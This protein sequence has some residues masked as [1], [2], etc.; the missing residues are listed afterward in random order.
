MRNGNFTRQGADHHPLFAQLRFGIGFIAGFD[1]SNA[2]IGF[3]SLFSLPFSFK[4]LWALPINYCTP[5]R[6]KGRER[7]CWLNV[8]LLGMSVALLAI[9]CLDPKE[10]PWFLATLLVIVSSFA[11]CLYIAGIAYELESIHENEYSM[12]SA[13]VI[14]GYR[15]GLVLSGAGSLYFASFFGWTLTFQCTAGLL[16]LIASII[17]VYPE[18][19]KSK[20]V[21]AEKQ[22]KIQDHSSVRS[23]FFHETLASPCKHFFAREHSLKILLFIF[24]FKLGDELLHGMSGPFYLSLGFNKIDLATANKIWGMGSTIA[25]A[26]LAAIYLKNKTGV[27]KLAEMNLIHSATLFCHGILSFVGK[28]YLCLYASV[29][30]ENLTGG[31]VFTA[32]ITF[33]WKNCDHQFA[34]AQYTLLWSVFT[35]KAKCIGFLGGLLATFC[36]WTV[37]FF[38]VAVIAVIAAVMAL[39][40][41]RKMIPVSKLVPNN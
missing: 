18:P 10:N 15:V 37:F 36:S 32:F 16:V 31:M 21:L 28:S 8:G 27:P 17:S 35:F 9:S 4:I 26:F 13:W 25:G 6:W 40:L 14:S 29:T 11:G 7:K 22:K 20:E 1:E 38:L 24:L 5:P 12:G 19:Y 39:I 34:A 30:L 23:L 33:L 3:F 2:L 41:S